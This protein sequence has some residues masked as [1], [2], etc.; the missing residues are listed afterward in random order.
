VTSFAELVDAREDGDSICFH[1][2]RDVHGA[3]GG[4]FGGLLAAAAVHA[5]RRLAPARTPAGLDCRFLRALPAGDTRATATV[6][7][8]GRSLTCT[9]VDLCDASGRLATTATVS[10]VAAEGL[11]AL[12]VGGQPPAEP[13]R[14]R[15]WSS[16]PGI[17]VP[18][19][20][21]LDPKVGVLD[22]GAIAAEITIPWEDVGGATAA[23]AACVAGDLCVGPPVAAACSG[24]W[25]PHP[26]PD[27]SLRFAPVT[28]PL[29]RL[30]GIGRVVRITG[31]QAVVGIDVHADGVPYAAGAATSLV[32][33][34][35]GT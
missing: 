5:G 19:M 7:H 12:D 1:F 22:D 10:F 9:R 35:E 31:G 15:P 16:P 23:E 6:L 17:E 8:E 11:H 3:F 4:A 28:A 32:L 29:A 34:S 33:K 25:L 18:I 26:N 14:W 2:G 13:V 30:T 20:A 24:A 27:V 21:L